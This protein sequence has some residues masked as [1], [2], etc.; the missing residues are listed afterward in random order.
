MKGKIMYKNTLIPSILILVGFY[1]IIL[2]TMKFIWKAT[3]DDSMKKLNQTIVNELH[4]WFKMSPIAVNQYDYYVI[5]TKPLYDGRMEVD[6]SAINK[7]F[8]FLNRYFDSFNYIKFA[9]NGRT[10]I[11]HLEFEI[12]YTHIKEENSLRDILRI[13][14]LKMYQEQIEEFVADNSVYVFPFIEKRMRIDIAYNENGRKSI[15]SRLLHEERILQKKSL[16]QDIE[17]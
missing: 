13:E 11:V 2:L 6:R 5:P 16:S 17:E 1:F 4:N 8:N 7:L 3:L 12:G 14:T 9:D 10:G 15:Q